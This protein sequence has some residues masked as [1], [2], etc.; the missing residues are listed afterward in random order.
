MKNSIEIQEISPGQI[1]TV[2]T[3]IDG[4]TVMEMHRKGLSDAEVLR[5]LSIKKFYQYFK[6][7]WIVTFPREHKVFKDQNFTAV[8]YMSLSYI[9]ERDHPEEIDY[10]C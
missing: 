9:H 1:K 5:K 2:I 3:T 4:V 6:G 8:I 7:E 10:I